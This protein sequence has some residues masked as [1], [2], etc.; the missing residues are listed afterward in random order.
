MVSSL[1]GPQ[2]SP[3]LA[4]DHTLFVLLL[5]AVLAVNHADELGSA[6]MNCSKLHAAS[7]LHKP[8]RWQSVGAVVGLMDVVMLMPHYRN[9]TLPL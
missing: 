2:V 3:R 5:V 6:H 9:H 1:L 8:S 7:P 4:R